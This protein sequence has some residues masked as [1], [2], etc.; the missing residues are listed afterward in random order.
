MPLYSAIAPLLEANQ[1]FRNGDHPDDRTIHGLNAGRVVGRHSTYGTPQQSV[2]CAV[3]GQ[4]LG[5]HGL[6]G[7]YT[8]C[9]G[10]Y[11][12]IHYDTKGKVTGYS[13]R[14]RKDF[15]SRYELYTG[16]TPT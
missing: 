3:C 4:T 10:D 7:T 9:P 13:V 12:I 11:I 2:A 14:D 5:A 16:G 6:L 15:E 1:W 8:V